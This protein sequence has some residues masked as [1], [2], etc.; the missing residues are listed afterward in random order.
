MTD[1]ADADQV[2]DAEARDRGFVSRGASLCGPAEDTRIVRRYSESLSQERALAMLLVDHMALF[3]SKS[4]KRVAMRHCSNPVRRIGL[5]RLVVL[6]FDRAESWTGH[7][8][9]VVYCIEHVVIGPANYTD[10]WV[11]LRQEALRCQG[12]AGIQTDTAEWSREGGTRG[13]VLGTSQ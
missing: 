13:V 11:A 8:I 3:C 1:L 7:L 9:W 10:G 6:A 2:F 4:L 5:V 12:F